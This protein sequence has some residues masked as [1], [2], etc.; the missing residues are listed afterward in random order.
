MPK[1]SPGSPNLNAGAG[2]QAPAFDRYAENYDRLVRESLRISGEDK[3]YYARRRIEWLRDC[4]Q[5]RGALPRLVLDFGCGTASA[6]ALLAEVLGADRVVGTDESAAVIDVARRERE[7]PGIRFALPRELEGGEPFEAAYCSGVFHHVAPDR[8]PD[9]VD[10]IRRLLAP[11]G[12]LSFWEHN[13]WSPAARFVMSRCE[14]DTGAIP[15]TARGA[16]DLLRRGGFETLRTDYLF[17]FPGALGRLRGLEPRLSALPL[18][19]QF[20]VLA[21]NPG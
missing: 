11:G 9:V 10:Q 7:R 17:I 3:D 8:R 13:A 2:P 20:Q 19:A 4:L 12:I 6:T 5:G 14:F 18:G 21:R 15:L 1:F 16:R